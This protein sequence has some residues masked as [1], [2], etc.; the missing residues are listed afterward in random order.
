MS[1]NEWYSNKQLFERLGELRD[2]F[3]NLRVEMQE[4]RSLIK[5]YNGLREE[6]V[7]VKQ[8]N[9]EIKEQL[10]AMLNKQSGKQNT[11]ET[12]R[13]WGGWIFGLITLLI[14]IYNQVN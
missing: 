10:Q 4:T 3:V 12:I 6:I 8:E 5:Q 9:L 7:L 1:D 13:N 11:T 2:D 14:L